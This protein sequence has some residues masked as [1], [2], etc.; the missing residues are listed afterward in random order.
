MEVLIK[1]I[2][3]EEK[4]MK[5]CIINSRWKV[6]I[7]ILFTILIMITSVSAKTKEGSF[8]MGWEPC[9]GFRNILSK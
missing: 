8:L 9:V 2:Q 7:L 4:H 3:F 6:S 1:V 5:S